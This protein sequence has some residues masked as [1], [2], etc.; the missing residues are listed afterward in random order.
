MVNLTDAQRAYVQDVV[1]DIPFLSFNYT[2][3]TFDVSDNVPDPTWAQIRLLY[4]AV[5]KFRSSPPPPPPFHTV[6]LDELE[7]GYYDRCLEHYC[8][9]RINLKIPH[10]QTCWM[11]FAIKTYCLGRVDPGTEF[12]DEAKVQFMESLGR[13]RREDFI[14]MSIYRAYRKNPK[15]RHALKKD[16]EGWLMFRADIPIRPLDRIGRFREATKD[17]LKKVLRY[18]SKERILGLLQSIET[19]GWDRDL[20]RKPGGVLGYSRTTKRYL[21][22]TG[23][24]RIAALKYLYSQGKINGA[25]L[26]EYPVITYPWGPWRHGRPHPDSPVCEWCE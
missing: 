14:A 3:G 21:V 10:E 20:A 19:R 18:R 11:R 16:D 26:I 5:G 24:H 15:I 1:K 23:K 13:E 12:G 9:E 6:R 4:K 8:Y 2:T 25:T 7:T 17:F 22:I